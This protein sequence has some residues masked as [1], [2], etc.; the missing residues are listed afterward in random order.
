MTAPRRCALVLGGSGYVGR[1]VVRALAAEGVRTRFTC[2]ARRDVARA[3]ADETGT[4]AEPVDLRDVAA[5]RA[6]LARLDEEGAL[7]DVVVHCAVVGGSEPLAEVTDEL[8]DR[9][10]A[11]NVRALHVLVQALVPRLG[12]RA[13]DIVIATAL[14]GIRDVPSSA[15][16]ASTQAA[17]LGMT[18]A[19]ASELGPRDVRVNLCLLGALGG[20]ISSAIDPSRLADYKKFSAFGRVGSPVEAARAIVRLALHNRWMTG[21]ILPVTGGL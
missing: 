12:G 3:L 18:R 9:M 19:L 11:V 8:W 6:L 21:S 4:R 15:H 20:G 2:H 13:A 14:D 7:P 5:I 1:E 10:H 16:F 17:L